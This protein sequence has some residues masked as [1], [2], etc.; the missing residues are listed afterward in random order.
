M[1]TTPHPA[2][3]DEAF[4]ANLLLW[5]QHNNGNAS[6]CAMLDL[7]YALAQRHGTA[8]KLCALGLPAILEELCSSSP[9]EVQRSAHRTLTALL[10]PTTCCHGPSGQQPQQLSP[11]DPRSRCQSNSPPYNLSNRSLDV[12]ALRTDKEWLHRPANS[13][14]SGATSSHA[15]GS[16]QGRSSVATSHVYFS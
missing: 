12:K 6:D 13:R 2:L 10:Q 4:L 7:L 11:Y 5:F 9:S 8:A 16:Q 14:S 3:Q 1:Y 15:F